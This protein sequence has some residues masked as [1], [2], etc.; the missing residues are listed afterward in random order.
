MIGFKV[1]FVYVIDGEHELGIYE[2]MV[3]AVGEANYQLQ[4]GMQE[5]SAMRVECLMVNDQ[6]FD[7]GE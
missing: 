3:E 6:Y 2:S 1:V 4:H 5:P 7:S